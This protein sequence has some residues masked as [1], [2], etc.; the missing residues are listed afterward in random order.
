[1]TG[2]DEGATSRGL[3]RHRRCLRFRAADCKRD[4]HTHR[5]NPH[6]SHIDVS[7]HWKRKTRFETGYGGWL[8]NSSSVSPDL[9]D[10]PPGVRY[11]ERG[12]AVSEER[13]SC[14]G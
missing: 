14:A 5:K 9:E 1:M 4:Q 13:R 11:E 12:P 2:V 6:S 8:A 7:Y 3:H 10:S